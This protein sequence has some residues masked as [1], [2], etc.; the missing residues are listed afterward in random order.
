MSNEETERTM[1]F[2]LN[3]QA[4][5]SV[6][7][8]LLK[9]SQQRFQQELEETKRQADADRAETRAAIDAILTITERTHQTVSTLAQVQAEANQRVDAFIVV[10][11][12]YI[13]DNQKPPQA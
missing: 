10:L 12:R 8:D 6:D 2:I 9:E 1:Q 11:E 13:T 7:I 3:Q 4:K 5:F